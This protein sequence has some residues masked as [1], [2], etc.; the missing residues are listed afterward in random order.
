MPSHLLRCATRASPESSFYAPSGL[1]ANG[2]VVVV[3][4][5]DRRQFFVAAAANV[6]ITSQGIVR[7]NKLIEVCN[8]TLGLGSF[9]ASYRQAKRKV[10]RAGASLC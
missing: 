9:M 1:N 5:F 8:M 6:I 7:A 4:A 3:V 2:E 10:A